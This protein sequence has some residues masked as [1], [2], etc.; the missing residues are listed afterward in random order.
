RLN[1]DFI[2]WL[3]RW[4]PRLIYALAIVVG[5]YAA[6]KY[7]HQWQA[8]RTDAAFQEF[9]DARGSLRG[10]TYSGSPDAIL[11]IA[12]KYPTRATIAIQARLDAADIYA[13]AARRGVYPGGEY[14]NEAD[15]LTP[16]KAREQNERARALYQQVID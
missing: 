14:I 5:L 2:Q 9:S 16:E 7:Y 3:Q 11:A 1:E 12:D 8:D 4:G 13:A 15:R 10:A 6:N